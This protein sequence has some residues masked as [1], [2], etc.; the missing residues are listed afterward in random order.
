ML[1]FCSHSRPTYP[2]VLHSAGLCSLNLYSYLSSRSGLPAPARRTESGP[3]A[4]RLI[5]V[6]HLR[7]DIQSY[8]P[9]IQRRSQIDW[10]LLPTGLS[11]VV[12]ALATLATL[13][14]SSFDSSSTTSS[15]ATSASSELAHALAAQLARHCT[16]LLVCVRGG[17]TLVLKCSIPASRRN[18][19]QC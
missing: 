16:H 14:S 1:L 7:N 15:K 10:Y 2:G 19:L 12:W 6:G 18:T 8:Q 13:P 3:R 5:F 11:N 17:C 4:L 9:H